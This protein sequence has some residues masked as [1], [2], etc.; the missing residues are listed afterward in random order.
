MKSYLFELNA[1]LVVKIQSTKDSFA[2][3]F[4]TILSLVGNDVLIGG[5]LVILLF[6]SA[7]KI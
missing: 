7:N 6:C 4:F 2:T 1:H 3:Q 5:V